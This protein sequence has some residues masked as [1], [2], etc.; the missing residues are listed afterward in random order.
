M[1]D[2]RTI[3]RKRQGKQYFYSLVEYEF[4]QAKDGGL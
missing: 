1:T 4:T 2:Q 3:V